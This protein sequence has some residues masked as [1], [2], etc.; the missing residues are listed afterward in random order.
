MGTPNEEEP[1]EQLSLAR[2][3]DLEGRHWGVIMWPVSYTHL[4]LPTICSV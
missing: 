1:L 4:T 2:H 3:R